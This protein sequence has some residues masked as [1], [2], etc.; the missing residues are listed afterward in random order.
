MSLGS[1]AEIIPFT[2]FLECRQ[3]LNRLGVTNDTFVT[4]ASPDLGIQPDA[5]ETRT[6][7]VTRR[8]SVSATVHPAMPHRDIAI[9]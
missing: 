6:I 1:P 7:T 2:R 5:A 9:V 8:R 4:P 3:R